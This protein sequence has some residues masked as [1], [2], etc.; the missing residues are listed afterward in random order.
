MDPISRL[1]IYAVIA[2]ILALAIGAAYFKGHSAGMAEVQQKFDLFTAQVNAAGEKARAD[3]LTKERDYA[4]QITTANAGRNDALN[5][6]RQ[7]TARLA[8]SRVSVVP[9]AA[10]GS[11]SECFDAKALT[12]AVERYRQRI[13]DLVTEGDRAQI[14]ATSIL[15]SWPQSSSPPPH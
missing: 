15:K 2:L 13:A 9:A 1:E 8:A 6:L 14:D 11:S 10:K 4:A 3:A 7:A 12:A 5:S